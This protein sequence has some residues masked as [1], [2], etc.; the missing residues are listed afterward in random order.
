MSGNVL[1]VGFNIVGMSG[2]GSGAWSRYVQI[3]RSLANSGIRIISRGTR[4]QEISLMSLALGGVH[5][6][7]V[8]ISTAGRWFQAKQLETF[9]HQNEIDVL[10]LEAPP[11]LP[12]RGAV[13]LA[14]IHDLR[15]H[16]GSVHSIR[17]PGA[18]YQR[19]ALRHHARRVD[20]ILALS[21]WAAIDIGK[22]LGLVQSH[23]HVVPPIIDM[24]PVRARS[25]AHV[26]YVLA[27]GHLERRK[28]LE[29]LLSAADLPDWPDGVELWIAGAD[30][31]EAQKLESRANQTA[32]A[33]RFLGPVS[34][35]DKLELLSGALA[36][37]V[38]S[39]IEG[40]G[41]VAVEAPA[42]GAPALVSDMS[43]LP[44][45]AFHPKAMLEAHN[46]HAWASRIN[47]L[48]GETTLRSEI[49]EAQR[50]GG[51]KFSSKQ[52]TK[53]LLSLYEKLLSRY[54]NPHK[55]R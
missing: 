5:F 16:R 35:L 4:E 34:E 43:A 6:Q 28:N 8:D 3:V 17:T 30:H 29:V 22:R 13:V 40:F 20:G 19:Y 23:I 15:H 9:I 53:S 32:L 2:P 26:P 12:C 18:V 52:V 21:D 10:H 48:S 47:E 44:E 39:T 1:T 42:H 46:P 54:I 24:S 49:L 51:S 38:P 31:G 45:L 25:P 41:I 33:T 7:V 50:A 55:K 11:Y 27:L 37:A 36:V 14:S